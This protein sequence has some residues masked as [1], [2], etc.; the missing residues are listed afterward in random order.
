MREGKKNNTLRVSSKKMAV[1]RVAENRNCRAFYPGNRC[2]M[3]V[4][5]APHRQIYFYIYGICIS[6]FAKRAV[7]ERHTCTIRIVRRTIVGTSPASL[8]PD[9]STLIQQEQVRAGLFRT[10]P[11]VIKSNICA[12]VVVN[13]RARERGEGRE[14]GRERETTV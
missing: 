13:D 11:S 5:S 3:E 9:R 8:I 12:P 10:F 4:T 14:E 2:W 6:E 7:G 1:T